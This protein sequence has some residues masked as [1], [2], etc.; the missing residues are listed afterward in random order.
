M[1]PI[2][3]WLLHYH[4]ILKN[5]RFKDFKIIGIWPHYV[6][7]KPGILSPLKFLIDYLFNFFEMRKWSRLYNKIG[8]EVYFELNPFKL[9]SYFFNSNTAFFNRYYKKLNV[10]NISKIKYHNIELGNEIYDTYLRYYNKAGITKKDM[11][12]VYSILNLASYSFFKLEEFYKKNKN[13]I[14]YYI[15]SNIS[16][17]Q[18]GLPAKFFISK[19]I[20]VIGGTDTNSYLNY[21]NKNKYGRNFEDYNKIYLKLKNKKKINYRSEK[22]YF[23]FKK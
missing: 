11:K 23:S 14:S 3:Y 21:Y 22:I 19:N 13:K 2:H 16:Y 20:K 9:R 15:T 4:Y 10:K 12:H 1:V 8:V 6:F 7:P 5:E 17:I 18:S